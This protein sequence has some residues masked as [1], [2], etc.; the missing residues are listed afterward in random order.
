MRPL[1]LLALFSAVVLHAA[2]VPLFDGKTFEGWEGDTQKTWRIVEGALVG[3]SLVEKV[4]H[5]EFLATK[6][7]YQDFELT[8]KF[9]L[10]GTE[11]FVNSGVQIRSVRIA[12]PPNEMRGYQADIGDPEWWGCLYDESRRNK[13]L[14]KSDMGK[15][16][17]VLKKNDWNEY[18]IRCEGPRIQLWIN[19][20]QTIDYTEPDA[21]IPQEGH[22]A[23]Q[24][25][26]GAKAEAWFKDI[27]IEALAAK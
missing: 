24:I 3:G 23:L 26:G 15:V 5:N 1:A 21:S 18:R 14:A 19:G 4:P 7:A 12:N 11:G 13:V 16:G 8:L 17:P 27:F 2:P 10:T 20:V 22:I 6:K 9:K 25:H